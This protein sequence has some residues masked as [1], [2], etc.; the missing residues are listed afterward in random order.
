MMG[1]R[2]NSPW[3][4][5]SEALQARPKNTGV[6]GIAPTPEAGPGTPFHFM[7]GPRH[8]VASPSGKPLSG[9]VTRAP[10]V[11]LP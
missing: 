10:M 5:A 8:R 6:V 2:T 7:G 3:E 9:S 1:V 11:T 4:P